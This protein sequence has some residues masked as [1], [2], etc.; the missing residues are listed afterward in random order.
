MG[1]S[2]KVEDLETQIN[3]YINSCEILKDVNAELEQEVQ[4]ISMELEEEKKRTWLTNTK[5][6]ALLSLSA[7][8]KIAH[9]GVQA[10]LDGSANF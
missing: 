8:Q 1:I 7:L 10:Y 3:D 2:F 4:D 9:V 6:F 5:Q